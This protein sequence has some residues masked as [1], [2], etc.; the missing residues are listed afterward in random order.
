MTP[1][2]RIRYLALHRI[3]LGAAIAAI[4]AILV[5]IASAKPAPVDEGYSITLGPGEIP[6]VAS[7]KLG[8]GEIP[9]VDYGTPSAISSVAGGGYDIG[10]VSSA[11]MLLLLAGGALAVIRY[12]RKTKLSPA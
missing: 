1:K 9:Y 2:S 6:Q 4:A 10:L 11:V 8:P 3:A 12:S 5:P 7:V